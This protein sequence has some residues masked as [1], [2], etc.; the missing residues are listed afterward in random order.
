M[1]RKI[2][3]AKEDAWRE[4]L[5]AIDDDPWGRPYRVV[6]GR[7]RAAAVPVTATMGRDELA[8]TVRELFPETADEGVEREERRLLTTMREE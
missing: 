6:L 1:R 5:Q 2:K 3:A 8:K 4:L 7:L